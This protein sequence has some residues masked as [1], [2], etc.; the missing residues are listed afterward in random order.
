MDFK[1]AIIQVAITRIGDHLII[2]GCFYHLCQSSHMKLQ[3]L[4]LKNKYDNDNNFSHYC[5]MVDS[6]AFSPLHKVIE[7]MGATQW[8]I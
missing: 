7:G 1:K 3:E 4:R 2:Q 6:L 5:S 8:R